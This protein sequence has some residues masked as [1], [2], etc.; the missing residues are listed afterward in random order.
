MSKGAGIYSVKIQRKDQTISK[1]VNE[2]SFTIGR[3]VDC[4]ISLNENSISRVHV[5]VATKNNQIWIED[6]GSSNGTFLN[7]LKIVQ[8]TWVNVVSTDFVRLGKS[9]YTVS[10]E[11]ISAVDEPIGFSQA[12][13]K[14]PLDDTAAIFPAMTP[15]VPKSMPGMKSESVKEDAAKSVAR[16]RAPIVD[17]NFEA[18][19]IIQNA[20]KKAA[21][22][23]YEGE[24][25]AEKRIQFLYS[26]AQERQTEAEKYYQEKI[27]QAHR[28]VEAVMRSSEN[29]GQDLIV[30][31]RQIAQEMRDEVELYV[32]NIRDKARKEVDHIIQESKK[33]AESLRKDAVEKIAGKAKLD[34][35]AIIAAAQSQ[36]SGIVD[37]ANLKAEEILAKA[38]EAIQAEDKELKDKISAG[39]N[40]LQNLEADAKDLE[41]GNLKL[42]ETIAT[43]E[44]SS[45][46]LAAE[47]EDLE[48]KKKDLDE[49][50]TKIRGEQELVSAEKKKFTAEKDELELKIKSLKDQAG[51]LSLSVS[52]QEERLKVS[53]RELNQRKSEYADKLEKEK[54][55]MLKASEERINDAQLEMGQ[56]LKKLE[57]ELLEEIV[58]RKET[59]IKEIIA[60]VEVHSAK[61]LESGKWDKISDEITD[62]IAA[63][64]EG[65]A[66]SF[67]GSTGGSQVGKKSTSLAQKKKAERTRWLLYGATCGFLLL[68]GGLK[69]QKIIIAD[70]NPMRTIASDDARRRQEDLEKRKFNPAQVAEVKDTYADA[71]IYTKGYTAKYLDP[72][73]QKV[74][75][76]EASAYL[77]KTWR[78]DEDKSIQ[79]ISM[80]AALVKD[81]QEKRLAIHPDFIKEG[82]AKMNEAE[83]S[84]LQRMK[85]LL[86]SEVRLE[87]Y[88]RFERKF[89]ELALKK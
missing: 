76:K 12:Q 5:T 61:V 9:D 68:M 88:R 74:F 32:D 3:S 41:S 52:A 89:V 85:I 24:K 8:N 56:R 60:V 77:L 43:F 27:A 62:G 75:Y 51:H 67:M 19:K 21:Q 28:E 45:K 16:E 17:G 81:L 1:V 72:E 4:T 86:G 64:I 57:K 6:R 33:E 7:D 80:S 23:V 34:G 82:L 13:K 78:L 59:L 46:K 70:Q 30:Q 49:V 44:L 11:L 71:V 25:S 10:I 69:V 20:N 47:V 31:A 84:T 35:E 40:R 48:S 36:A 26:Q 39:E 53:E 2:E 38:R 79:A 54:N 87:S 50:M 66:V 63:V 18:E 15:I 22:I 55:V 42:K 37:F 29:Q 14:E 58:G 65:K 73:F 83:A